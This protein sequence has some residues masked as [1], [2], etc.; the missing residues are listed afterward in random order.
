MPV[1]IPGK[2]W[3]STYNNRSFWKWLLRIKDSDVP[4][5]HKTWASAAMPL[6]LETKKP[7]GTGSPGT[8]DLGGER[9]GVICEKSEYACLPGSS[10]PF[11]AT[12]ITLVL[13]SS[14][15][16]SR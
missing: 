15:F 9:P 10:G 6:K 14:I 12:R 3:I 5:S 4:P 16:L 1:F 8:A 13:S 11:G 2:E 7:D